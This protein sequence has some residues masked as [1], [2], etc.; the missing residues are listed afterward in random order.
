M[1]IA[2]W[3]VQRLGKATSDA[4]KAVVANA[5]DDFFDNRDVSVVVLCEVSS[6]TTVSADSAKEYKISKIHAATRRGRRKASAQLGYTVISRGDTGFEPRAYEVPAYKD[7]FGF[8]PWKK[9][10]GSFS[11]NSKRKVLEFASLCDDT[12]VYFYHANASDLSKHLVPWVAEAIRLRTEKHNYPFLLIGDLNCEPTELEVSLKS[13]EA[14]NY[15]KTGW[16][17]KFKVTYGGKTHNAHHGCLKT[18]DYVIG[19]ANEA[20]TVSTIDTRDFGNLEDH[21]DHL[22]I[23]VSI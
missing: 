12:D 23:I 4:A 15:K 19:K 21:P 2:F 3:N 6:D 9:G 11:K 7:V 13:Y 14:P 18:L 20:V 17:G 8:D 10:G 1:N 22:P 16:A 5:I